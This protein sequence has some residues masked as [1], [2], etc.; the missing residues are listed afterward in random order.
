MPVRAQE[1]NFEVY[2]PN[3]CPNTTWC[4][5]EIDYLQDGW[6]SIPIKSIAK[7]LN[8]S[9]NAINIMKNRL[10]LG[11][12]LEN[13]EYVTF[14]Q[15]LLALGVSG[16]TRYFNISW[17]KNKNFPIKFKTVNKCS[18][19]VVYLSDFWTWAEANRG[20]IDWSR[21]EKNVLGKEPG[22][23]APQRKAD[24]QKRLK[25]KTSDWT[26]E[27]DARLKDLLR[28]FRYGYRELSSMLH[29]SEGGI[30]RRINDLGLKERPVKADNRINWTPE[31]YARIGEMIKQR[32]SYELMSDELGKSTK[33]IRGRVYCMYLTEN[34][35]RVAAMIGN[36]GWGDGRPGVK[37]SS[38][39][40]TVAEKEQIR[41]DLS[42]LAGVVKALIC[43]HYDDN[44]YWQRELCMNWGD[45]CT[46]GEANCDSCSSFVRIRP[47][48]C[49]RCGATFIKRKKADIC[50]RCAAARKKQ[51]QRKWAALQSRRSGCCSQVARM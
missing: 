6:G 34:I 38:R 48:Y 10:G 29:R 7:R 26:K 27:E 4:K 32:L 16:G 21:V 14:H 8:R 24:H 11:A 46:A 19:K 28:Q 18:F 49:R 43:R 22:W 17:I 3:R 50:P 15:L 36:G 47:Q 31:E 44:D 5:E 33:A 37:I 39:L 20:M 2:K 41:Q 45:G 25:I 51:Y 30:Q 1:M 12:F 13:G 40:L 42:R 23:V 35:D 9:V